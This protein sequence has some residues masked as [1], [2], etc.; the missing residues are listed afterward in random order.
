MGG[1]HV[2]DLRRGYRRCHRHRTL[3]DAGGY[4]ADPAAHRDCV[5]GLVVHLAAAPR[6]GGDA[7]SEPLSGQPAPGWYGTVFDPAHAGTE[8]PLGPS[9]APVVTVLSL[10][11]SMAAQRG[12]LP[13][14]R[15][16]GHHR[17]RHGT[18]TRRGSAAQVE[19]ATITRNHWRAR[20]R[21]IGGKVLL[22]FVDMFLI[23]IAIC[24]KYVQFFGLL[25]MLEGKLK[26]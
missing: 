3:L 20:S 17:L 12:C 16:H 18:D 11:A 21:C 14:P 24:Y 23:L 13:G 22:R 9:S 6:S 15:T 4:R 8:L 2:L 1:G 26:K 19:Q 10:P 5:L 7:A 25:I